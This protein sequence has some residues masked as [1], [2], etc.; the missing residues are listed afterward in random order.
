MGICSEK[1]IWNEIQARVEAIVEGAELPGPS[2][3]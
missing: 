2:A 3:V 1:V